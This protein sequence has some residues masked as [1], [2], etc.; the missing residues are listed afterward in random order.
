M[1]ALAC[2]DLRVLSYPPEDW[3]RKAAEL[4]QCKV[5]EV[6]RTKGEC[7]ILLTGGRSAARLYA[8]WAK[9]ESFKTMKGVSAYF[10]DERCVPPGHADSNYALVMRTLFRDKSL[11]ARNQVFRIEADAPDVYSAARRYGELLPPCVDILLLSVGEDGHIAS[12]FPGSSALM[13]MEC[14]VVPV[15]GPKPPYER[16]TIT[17]PVIAAAT[18]T[19]V[20]A[21]GREKAEILLRAT[22]ADAT[23]LPARL[24]L[25]GIWLLDTPLPEFTQNDI[26]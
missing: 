3:P 26:G 2:S 25:R 6:L 22:K 9:C 20:L 11:R 13:E 18:T 12:L 23:E 5:D 24:V 17:P 1:S 19:F 14:R 8:T 21:T 10:G 7:S 4:I 16:V 15:T